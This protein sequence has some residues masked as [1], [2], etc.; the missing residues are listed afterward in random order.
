MSTR[1]HIAVVTTAILT[2]ALG[3]VGLALYVVLSISLHAQLDRGLAAEGQDLRDYFLTS[4]DS[5]LV[6]A[7]LPVSAAPFEA[8]APSGSVFRLVAADGRVLAR[9]LGDRTV[10]LDASAHQTSGGL[11]LGG[12]YESI[13]HSGARFRVFSLPVRLP[14][15]TQGLLQVAQPLAAV[16]QTLANLRLV[17]LAGVGVSLLF[18][19]GVGLLVAHVAAKPIEDVASATARIRAFGEDN[20]RL[21]LRGHLQ[22]PHWLAQSLNNLLDRVAVAEAAA[23]EA[24]AV[25]AQCAAYVQRQLGRLIAQQ[26]DLNDYLRADLRPGA[27]DDLD[28]PPAQRLVAR[29]FLRADPHGWMTAYDEVVAWLDAQTAALARWA[30]HLPLYVGAQ[31]GLNVT[32]AKVA[33]APLLADICAARRDEHG[34]RL[35][36]TWQG[37]CEPVLRADPASLQDA[38]AAVIDHACGTTPAGGAVTVTLDCDGTSATATVTDTGPGM[39]ADDLPHVFTRFTSAAGADGGLGLQFAHDVIAQHGGTI[40]VE[41]TLGA[42]SVFTVRLPREGSGEPAAV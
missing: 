5:P 4:A 6:G 40:T 10:L 28:M 15:Q 35:R 34:A 2:L 33:L 17:L 41:S 1:L 25:R 9:S 31:T 14:A 26:R 29:D 12:G 20:E 11:P 38:L 18:A 32:L 21:V 13:D 3:L 8:V 23:G 24:S 30:D 22:E 39:H 16:E 27:A 36:L 19:V 42:G 7:T 37:A